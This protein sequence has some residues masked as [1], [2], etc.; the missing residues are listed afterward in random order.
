[1]I[2]H[3]SSINQCYQ[4]LIL[5]FFLVFQFAKMGK[6]RSDRKRKR[7]NEQIIPHTNDTTED[8]GDMSQNEMANKTE[9]EIVNNDA[10]NADNLENKSKTEGGVPYIETLNDPETEA[11]S[12]KDGKMDEVEEM[13]DVEEESKTEPTVGGGIDVITAEPIARDHNGND[14]IVL[15]SEV[16]IDG[17]YET[18][19]N[20]AVGANIGATMTETEAGVNTSDGIALPESSTHPT[21]IDDNNTSAH[22]AFE[23]PTKNKSPHDNKSTPVRT[24]DAPTPHMILEGKIERYTVT[25]SARWMLLMTW[26]ESGADKYELYAAMLNANHNSWVPR[27]NTE[28]I[29]NNLNR[30]GAKSKDKFP[31]DKRISNDMVLLVVPCD[32]VRSENLLDSVFFLDSNILLNSKRIYR[33]IPQQISL[34]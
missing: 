13:D 16:E 12:N 25:I 29:F 18:R 30:L 32:V 33:N 6:S 14:R 11:T 34:Q 17:L 8:N 9:T 24:P 19:E 10:V 2:H 21:L 5:I 7:V 26:L 15:E 3:S 22:H 28:M 27:D 1:M 4:S 20:V 31:H 23:T